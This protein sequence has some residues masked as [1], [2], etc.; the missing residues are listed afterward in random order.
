MITQTTLE[1]FMTSYLLVLKKK[2]ICKYGFYLN[3]SLDLILIHL[4]MAPIKEA[5]T[6]SEGLESR[7]FLKHHH[8][9]DGWSQCGCRG[10]HKL[11]ICQD[12]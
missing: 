3:H 7:P 5:I 4:C 11:A 6:E 12:P 1:V 10:N 8:C 9:Q 2:K